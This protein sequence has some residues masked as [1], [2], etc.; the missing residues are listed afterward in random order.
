MHRADSVEVINHPFTMAIDRFGSKIFCP[1]LDLPSTPFFD[2]PDCLALP[3]FERYRLKGT[4]FS[5]YMKA[6]QNQMGPW[7]EGYRLKGTGFS[8]YRRSPQISRGFG[9]KG[10]T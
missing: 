9:L 5:P 10:T 4:G 2:I 8:P 6:P 1:S 3:G 7:F